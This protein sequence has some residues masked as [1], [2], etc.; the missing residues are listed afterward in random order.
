MVPVAGS[1]VKSDFGVAETFGA[2]EAFGAVT[3]DEFAVF[4]D[5]IDVDGVAL[6]TGGT[7]NDTV[8]GAFAFTVGF[9]AQDD[10]AAKTDDVS[11]SEIVMHKITLKNSAAN[12]FIILALLVLLNIKF[13]NFLLI[14]YAFWENW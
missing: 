5:V 4:A 2:A 14:T 6:K 7:F 8:A 3:T 10:S 11:G 1:N 9:G 13:C 12:R